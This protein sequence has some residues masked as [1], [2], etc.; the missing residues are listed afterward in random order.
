MIYGYIF[1]DDV[2][3][4]RYTGFTSNRGWTCRAIPHGATMSKTYNHATASWTSFWRPFS[5]VLLATTVSRQI[6][7]ET[8]LLPFF[9]GDFVL[10]GVAGRRRFNR[11]MAKVQREAARSLIFDDDKVGDKVPVLSLYKC[12]EDREVAKVKVSEEYV[13]DLLVPYDLDGLKW[14]KCC[15]KEHGQVVEYFGAR[16]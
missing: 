13:K 15:Q 10:M 14:C 12:L 2:V 5:Q 7:M 3:E 6:Y 4:L 11:A 16:V 9:S 1:T 8:H